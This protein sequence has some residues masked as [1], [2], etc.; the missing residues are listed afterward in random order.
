M[1]DMIASDILRGRRTHHTGTAPGPVTSRTLLEAAGAERVELEQMRM[2]IADL[3]RT[4]KSGSPAPAKLAAI[5]DLIDEQVPYGEPDQDPWRTKARTGDPGAFTE[6]ARRDTGPFTLLLEDLTGHHVTTAGLR[7]REAGFTRD[8]LKLLGQPG[9]VRGHA[10]A[11]RLV[12]A[13]VTVAQVACKLIPDL[14]PAQACHD[15]GIPVRPGDPV[16]PPTPTSVGAALAPFGLTRDRATIDPASPPLVAVITARL[17]LSGLPV[18]VT[19]E[20]VR[21]DVC[22]MAAARSAVRA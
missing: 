12:A 18:G 15:L 6:L 7:R 3:R 20:R 9:P 13:K 10:R 14:I 16:P 11:C 19:R 4:L 5:W 8:E 1:R 22:V 2:L 17:L 21:L